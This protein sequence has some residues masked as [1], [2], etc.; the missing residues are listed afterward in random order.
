MGPHDQALNEIIA[1]D[2]PTL[3]RFMLEGMAA[4]GFNP[5]K[6]T[7]REWNKRHLPVVGARHP[8]DP[9]KTLSHDTVLD[10]LEWHAVK[11]IAGGTLLP[12]TSRSDYEATVRTAIREATYLHVG[13]DPDEGPRAAC[14]V[15]VNALVRK[16]GALNSR[17]SEMLFVVYDP[18]KG[19]A[20]SMYAITPAQLA[21][22]VR[23]WR[24]HRRFS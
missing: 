21:S 19:H 6:R 17:P 18:K 3:K 24:R 22:R 12:A 1:G 4:A 23:K 9:T 11:H 16:C 2:S 10:S 15:P 20:C 7:V 14:E 8:S 5:T 13:D